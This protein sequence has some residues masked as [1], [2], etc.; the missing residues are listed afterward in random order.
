MASLNKVMIIGNLGSD[1]ETVFTQAGVAICTISVAT[2]E[3]W[4]DKNTG[5]KK[6]KTEWH[7]IKFFSKQAETIQ[8]YMSKGSQIYVEGKNQ[9]SSYEK[10]GIIR[11][12]TDIIATT[13]QFIGSK[14]D[15]GQAD[16]A[17]NSGA[18][19]PQNQGGFNQN[20]PN[21]NQQQQQSG[22]QQNQNNSGSNQ[23]QERPQYQQKQQNSN[24]NKGFQQ[25]GYQ[26][27]DEDMP[28]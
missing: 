27:P 10:D 19:Q 6:E 4:N 11:Y 22:F 2:S 25:G 26:E 21:N 8:Q 28:F 9:T 5:E 3:T 17:Q 15:G 14:G 20:Q 13:F 24:Q 23:S 7:R 1:P 16:P 18:Q 12:S